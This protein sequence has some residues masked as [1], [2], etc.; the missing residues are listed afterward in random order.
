M[1]KRSDFWLETTSSDPHYHFR[2]QPTSYG[3]KYEQNGKEIKPDVHPCQ[4]QLVN[5]FEFHGCISEKHRLFQNLQAYAET[6]LNENV[7]DYL[8]LTFF[9][10][11]DARTMKQNSK[12]MVEFMNAF[13]A[14]DDI[15]KR[16]KKFYEKLD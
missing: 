8:P 1:A 12:S 3:L 2:W 4:K 7:F 14:L 9:V 6:K 15:S 16:T 10:E 11:I 5:H 13:Y